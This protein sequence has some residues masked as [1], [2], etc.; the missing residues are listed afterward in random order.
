MKGF[1]GRRSGLLRNHSVFVGGGVEIKGLDFALNMLKS[2]NLS[3]QQPRRLK[4]QNLQK[5]VFFVFLRHARSG[6]SRSLWRSWVA[7]AAAVVATSWLSWAG[8]GHGGRE[9][10]GGAVRGLRMRLLPR[11][12]LS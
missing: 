8:Y 12:P 11:S 7:N 4:T 9:A 10:R 6:V 2:H 3:Q 1:S 5:L